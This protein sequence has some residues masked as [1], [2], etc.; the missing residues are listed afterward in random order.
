MLLPLMF[1]DVWKN[2][3]RRLIISLSIVSLA[4]DY[5][6]DQAKISWVIHFLVILC[7]R[8]TVLLLGEAEK[9]KTMKA[10]SFS[11]LMGDLG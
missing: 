6:E 3:K 4:K 1:C 11:S 9:A 8:R 2:M 5:G 7:L 10:R